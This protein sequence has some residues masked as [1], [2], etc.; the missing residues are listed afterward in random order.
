MKQASGLY[1]IL[2]DEARLRLLRVLSR[3]RLNVGELT[4]V[5]GL[6]QSGVSR[7]LGL[8]K[9]AGLVGEEKDGGFTFYRLAREVRENGDGVLWAML[10]AQFAE[11]ADDPAV[12]ADEARLQEVLR[13][14]K[15]NFETHRSADPRDAR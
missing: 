2:G 8:L 13:V 4:G 15:E 9:D 7:H 5:L 3:E 11:A 6:A 10:E 14:R 1:R 12:R